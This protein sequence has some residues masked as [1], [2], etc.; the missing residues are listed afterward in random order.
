MANY[1][2]N[3]LQWLSV[4]VLL[5]HMMHIFHIVSIQL[6]M[7]SFHNIMLRNLRFYQRNL[8]L[9]IYY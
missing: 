2:H 3:Q 7:Y 4:D 8:F 5:H 9:V 6:L 1:F